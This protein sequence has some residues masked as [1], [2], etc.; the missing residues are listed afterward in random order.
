MKKYIIILVLF[1]IGTNL[2]SAEDTPK[3]VWDNQST[4]S[5][6]KNA[7]FIWASPTPTPNITPVLIESAPDELYTIKIIIISILIILILLFLF[8]EFMIKRKKL[9]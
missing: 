3:F 8:I 9:P 6:T 2:V 1:I 4:V 7:T 5:D